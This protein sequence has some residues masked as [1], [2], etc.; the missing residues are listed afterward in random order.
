MVDLT[1]G[2]LYFAAIFGLL[3]CGIIYTGRAGGDAI[4][5]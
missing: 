1:L 5:K 2:L 4:R 3:T